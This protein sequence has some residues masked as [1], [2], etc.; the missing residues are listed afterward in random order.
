MS[1]PPAVT[2]KVPFDADA[3]PASAGVPMSCAA[4]GPGTAANT[5]EAP[6][7]A[8]SA[9]SHDT[10][11]HLNGRQIGILKTREEAPRVA[12]ELINAGGQ[13]EGGKKVATKCGSTITQS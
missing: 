9:R 7:S 1:T 10:R 4:H 3:L 12:P 2:V 13:Q 5:L 8:S 11:M 6:D